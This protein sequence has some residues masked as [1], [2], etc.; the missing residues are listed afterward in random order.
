MPDFTILYLC[1]D[2]TG[3][4]VT[5]RAQVADND[6]ALGMCIEGLTKSKFWKDTCVFVEEDDPQA[7]WDHVDGH[8]SPCLVISPYSRGV[9]RVSDFCNQTSVVRSIEHILGL[10]SKAMFVANS[11]LMFGCF[12]RKLDL[13]P[14]TQ[15]PNQIKLDETKEVAYGRRF[16]LSK[17]DLVDDKAFNRAI[18]AESMPGRPYP[19][20]FEGSHGRGLGSRGLARVDVASKD[21]D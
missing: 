6:L 8:R 2:H 20:E 17:P 21:D 4:P 10:K 7:G 14:Y 9:G 16:D 13:T 19:S 5:G 3:G 1:C 18:W 11:P 15:R 12:G